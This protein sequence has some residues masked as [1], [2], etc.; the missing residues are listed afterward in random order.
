MKKFKLFDNFFKKKK[1]L[2]N[3]KTI[4]EKILE[5]QQQ[6]DAKKRNT[7]NNNA[8]VNILIDD[9]LDIS[10]KIDLSKDI[11]KKIGN[12]VCFEDNGVRI[13]INE[14]ADKEE[15]LHH[16]D[17]IRTMMEAKM[18]YNDLMETFKDNKDQI[19]VERTKASMA[20]E[21][22]KLFLHH[23]EDKDICSEKKTH[24][25]IVRDSCKLVEM[26]FARFDINGENNKELRKTL[27]KLGY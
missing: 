2:E 27:E 6:E 1:V 23:E 26:V 12:G 11:S 22:V 14:F 18:M 16:Y 17:K 7:I 4:E 20:F 15:I 10:Q 9:N 25:Q 24:L 21:L 5:H 13:C 3:R 19:A 8:F